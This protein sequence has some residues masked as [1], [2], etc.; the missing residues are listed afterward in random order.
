MEIGIY[1]NCPHIVIRNTLTTLQEE[2]PVV[3]VEACMV[4]PLAMGTTLTLLVVAIKNQ[5]DA[6]R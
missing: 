2:M 1:I 4:L 3:E 5:H 6:T